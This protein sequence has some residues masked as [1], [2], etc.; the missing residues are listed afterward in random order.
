VRRRGMSTALG[1]E[2]VFRRGRRRGR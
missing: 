2:I 1:R